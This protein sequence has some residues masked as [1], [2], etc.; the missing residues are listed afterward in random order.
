VVVVFDIREEET[1]DTSAAI[2]EGNGGKNWISKNTK[3]V[4]EFA[5]MIRICKDIFFTFT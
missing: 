5:R 3:L 4:S 1:E 2:H